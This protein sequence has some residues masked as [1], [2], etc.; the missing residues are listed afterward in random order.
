MY[1]CRPPEYQPLEC[2]PST[3]W[4][5]LFTLPFLPHP[6]PHQHTHTHFIPFSPVFIRSLNHHKHTILTP[7]HIP[8]S[9]PSF[10]PTT[11]TSHQPIHS[12]PQVVL[13][14]N[15]SPPT[16]PTLATPSLP[17]CLPATLS[18]IHSPSHHITDTS[19]LTNQS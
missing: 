18:P 19:H 12:I 7:L 6:Q 11:T 8:P 15:P 17:S 2:N 1:R 4:L 13:S 5:L 14:Y 16:P 3:T 10:T 9:Q